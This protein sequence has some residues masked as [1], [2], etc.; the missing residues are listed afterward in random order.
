MLLLLLL[1]N[2]F[3]GDPEGPLAE[4]S[5]SGAFDTDF[6]HYAIDERLEGFEDE[7]WLLHYQEIVTRT[8][9]LADAER[10][11]V[12]LQF[13]T[14]ALL[15][16]RYYLDDEPVYEIDLHDVGVG[17]PF[18]QSYANVEKAW[19]TLRL[20]NTE[21][22][23][24][25]AYTSFGR[26]IAL[27]VVRNSDIDID[28]SIRGVKSTSSLGDVD[29][30]FFTG[31]ANT[32][33]VLQDNPN[34]LLKADK[35]HAVTGVQVQRW[36]LGPANLGF[37]AVKYRF[38]RGPDLGLSPLHAYG[39]DFDAQVVGGTLEFFGLGGVDWFFEGDLFDHRANE[40]GMDPGY[41]GYMSAAAY[42]G[43]L[44]ILVEARRNYNTELVNLF[45]APDGYEF[46][47]GPT[48]E[49]ERSITEDSSSAVNSNDIYGGR[50]RVDF[51]AKPGQVTPY[52]ALMAARDRD[53][54]GGHFN[55]SPET[56]VHPMVGADIQGGQSNLL[57]N[58][59]FRIDKRDDPAAGADRMAHFDASLGFP[60]GP[61]HG[62]FIWDY[63]TFWWGTN[64]PQQEDFMNSTVALAFN[65]HA[66]T[67]IFYNDLTNDP[68]INTAG[69]LPEVGPYQIYGATELQWQPRSST[70]IKAFYG[71][72]KA[73]IRCAG[74]QCKR[75]PGFD[76][77]RLTL[78]HAF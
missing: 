51:A 33:Q 15:S 63:Y 61:V 70:T 45:S 16:A 10:W 25:D 30:V 19:T 17:F 59:G 7:R 74:G 31:I 18:P 5:V 65:H 39:Q 34:R 43:R 6:R 29:L 78:T 37:H 21:V 47:S 8:N 32:Q 52:V 56:I 73:G 69:N 62:E 4:A 2:A 72:Y 71:A 22:Q 57:L 35:H 44:V 9:L 55:L 13:D 58:A 1:P 3:A 50:V 27:N 68:L 54:A 76:G 67:L 12:G 41:A 60:A 75:L 36:D 49:Y 26:G 20:G 42:P 40:L 23:F 48:L 38:A 46:A 66:W 64:T 53:L 28:T 77:G 14:V 11:Q 24:G